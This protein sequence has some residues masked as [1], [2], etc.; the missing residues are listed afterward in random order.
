M[1]VPRGVCVGRFDGR[2]CSGGC[3]SRLRMKKLKMSVAWRKLRNAAFSTIVFERS[4]TKQN[5]VN[6]NR[7]IV[8]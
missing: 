5:Q 8:W 6:R 1:D 7:V 2:T 3:A 4:K